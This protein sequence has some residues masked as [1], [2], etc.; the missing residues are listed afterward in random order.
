MHR[1]KLKRLAGATGAEFPDDVLAE[2]GLSHG[3]EVTVTAEA[4]R[5]VLSKASAATRS[6]DALAAL[7]SCIETY[8]ATLRRLAK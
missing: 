8:D 7:E 6:Q 4:G 2:A 1:T 5:L 3:D